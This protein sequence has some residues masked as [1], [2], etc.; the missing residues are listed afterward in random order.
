MKKNLNRKFI[1]NV[2]QNLIKSTESLISKNKLEHTL[3][4]HEKL[5]S[6]CP[7]P[8]QA[9]SMDLKNND[10]IIMKE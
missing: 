8:P 2:A 4:I 9:N 10:G 6:I 7:P 5:T 3:G 1:T